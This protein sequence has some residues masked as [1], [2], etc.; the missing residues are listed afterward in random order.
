VEERTLRT[1]EERSDDGLVLDGVER[2]CGIDHASANLEQ[3]RTT[4]GNAQLQRVNAWQGTVSN[5]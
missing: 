3:M 1:V 2:T 5:M 4:R